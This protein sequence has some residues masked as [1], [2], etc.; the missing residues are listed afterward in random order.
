M[1]SFVELVRNWHEQSSSSGDEF[2]ALWH[3]MTA[4]AVEVLDDDLVMSVALAAQRS[5]RRGDD[6]KGV[7]TGN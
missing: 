3:R 6:D 1:A 5:V 7:E 2:Q 4:K